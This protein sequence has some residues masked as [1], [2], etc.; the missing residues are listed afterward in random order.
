MKKHPI[1]P[2]DLAYINKALEI[3]KSQ[4]E[5]EEAL[6]FDDDEPTDLA[7][8]NRSPRL[9]PNE[10]LTVTSNTNDS[11]DNHPTCLTRASGTLAHAPTARAP[12]N[13]TFLPKTSIHQTRSRDELQGECCG[14]QMYTWRSSR[15]H[16]FWSWEKRPG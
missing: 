6:E 9:E 4:V 2:K 8:D 13:G 7:N 15:H 11:V 16:W 5:C 12:A 14:Y 1:G 10:P 3:H